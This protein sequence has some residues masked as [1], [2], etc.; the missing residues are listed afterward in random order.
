MVDSRDQLNSTLKVSISY[1]PYRCEKKGTVSTTHYSS[2]YQ[3]NLG[4]NLAQISKCRAV[5]ERV[6]LSLSVRHINARLFRDKY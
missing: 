5:L 3:V 1:F 2:F 4:S 6:R